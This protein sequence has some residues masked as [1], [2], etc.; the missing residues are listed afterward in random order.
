MD[1]KGF[2]LGLIAAVVLFLLWKKEIGSDSG[3]LVGPQPYSGAMPQTP[4]GPPD[5]AVGGCVGCSS[6]QA[7][8]AGA[9]TFL[10]GYGGNQHGVTVNSMSPSASA[11]PAAQASLASIGTDGFITPGTPPLQ[12]TLGVG[13]FYAPSGVTP[14]TNFWSLPTPLMPGSTTATMK[15]LTVSPTPNV[16]GSATTPSNAVPTRAT[17]AVAPTMSLGFQQRYSYVGIPRSAGARTFLTSV[18]SQEPV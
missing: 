13:S 14:D 4:V 15:P 9:R 12:G 11:A 8:S 10:T 6:A 7:S 16:A 18:A 2:F 5:T 17:Q 3:A 1:S